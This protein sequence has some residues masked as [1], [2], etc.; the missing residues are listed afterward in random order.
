MLAPGTVIASY[1][2]ESRIGGGGMGDVFVA[3]DRKLG[4]RVALKVLKTEHALSGPHLA[5]LK[6]E[7]RKLAALNHPNIATLHGIEQLDDTQVL[8]LELIEGQTLRELLAH[9]A[10]S[11]PE[12]LTIAQQV[13]AALDAAHE[14]G[15]VHC[16]LKPENI[17]VRAD[18]TVKVLDFDV[19]R[20]FD[21]ANRLSTPDEATVTVDSGAIIG[22]VAYM[23][24]EQARGLSIDRRADNWGFGCVLYEMLTGE[25]AFAGGRADALASVL[26]REPDYSRLPAGLPP[27][28]GTLLRRCLTKNARERLR[29][30]GD[31]RIELRDA[32]TGNASELR[33]RAPPHTWLRRALIGTGIVAAMA[34][35]AAG[36]LAAHAP[37]R[38][39][40][41]IVRFEIPTA[42]PDVNP[43]GAMLA[44]S[45]DGSRIAYVD[46]SGLVVRARDRLEARSVYR[47]TGPGSGAPFFSSDGEWL[48]FTDGQ[49]LLKLPAAG[50]AVV[51]IAA[52]GH[53]AF[54]SSSGEDV[55]FA[56]P[57]GIF[58]LRGDAKEPQQ[59][60]AN[61]GTYEQ[62]A[63]PQLLPNGAAVLFT[64]ISTRTNTP[65]AA[66][67]ASNTRIDVLDLR[68]NTP[69]TLLRGASRAHY[70]P[71]GHLLYVADGRLMA[72]R[73]DMRTLQLRGEPAPVLPGPVEEFAVAGDGTLVYRPA[74][75]AALN[76]LVWVDRNGREETLGTPPR[77]YIYPRMS[78]EGRRIALDVGG[79]DRDIWIWHI[80]NRTLERFTKDPAGNTMVAWS[81]DGRRLAFGSDR[82]G[83]SNVF[84]QAA[85]G[86][87]EPQ[88]LLPEDRLQQ[89]LSFAPDGR[90]LYSVDVPG[91]S[92]DV[93]ALVP[94]EQRVEQL[95]TGAATE[96]NAE[97]SPDGRWLAYESDESGQL[98]I[99]VRAYPDTKQ[100]G[101]YQVSSG[102]G[103]TPAWSRDGQEI[104][105]RNYDGAILAARVTA[106][107][108]FGTQP[109]KALFQNDSYLARGSAAGGRS[110]DLST[111]GSR[112][113][114][115]KMVSA[116]NSAPHSLVVVL[117]WH[118]ELE[119][120]VPREN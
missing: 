57:R 98:E 6:S 53:A 42:L 4:R 50:G 64:V 61:T 60:L 92:R 68:T 99:Y 66:L 10:L 59:L 12:A 104:Y 55:L 80:D 34:L 72:S 43:L 83:V 87:D 70:L 28:I 86:S 19:A 88:R 17:R 36:W 119:R 102:G 113:L 109:A 24:P 41:R 90:L 97:V 11:I 105:F 81:P 18:G 69:R 107:A 110:F 93:Y 100:G 9:G 79:P 7:A 49:A 73:F 115:L 3:L 20:T 27:A 118:A 52:T 71:S 48:G 116:A 37:Q 58:R 13:A 26:T 21:D 31:A 29:D 91:H 112:F 38:T 33:E 117:D 51:P 96:I 103:R 1:V 15:I 25:R 46:D 63:F 95:L 75:S 89:P 106:T 74:A 45:P 47:L 40:A 85:D 67:L 65:R 108:A 30:I 76:E 82:F 56:N 8:V 94:G 16:D 62:P 14:H 54:A 22:T 39:A 2:V 5:R 111:D 101:R 114:M 35:G 77:S 23:S 84:W 120:L 78:P 44:I 32:L